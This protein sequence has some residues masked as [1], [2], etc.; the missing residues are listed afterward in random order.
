VAVERLPL[1]VGGDVPMEPSALTVAPT[2]LVVRFI[3]RVIG[4]YNARPSSPASTGDVALARDVAPGGPL[5]PGPDGALYGLEHDGRSFWATTDQGLYRLDPKTRR[6]RNVSAEL[7]ATATASSRTYQLSLRK[8]AVEPGKSVWVVRNYRDEQQKPAPLPF[9]WHYDVPGDRWEH[10]P[11]ATGA[12]QDEHLYVYDRGTYAQ[13]RDA[14]WLLTNRGPFR[15]D[16]K[17]HAFTRVG[18]AFDA[19][20]DLGSMFVLPDARG[21]PV[22]WFVGSSTVLRVAP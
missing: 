20:A 3:P 15:F 16:R 12:G 17:A 14:V 6:W 4:R 18:P 1:G 11:I 21:V 19:P 8:N 7:G 13:E 2:S 22:R 5:G 10:I 9:L